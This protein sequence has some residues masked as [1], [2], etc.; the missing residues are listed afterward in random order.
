[1]RALAG[2][3]FTPHCSQRHMTVTDTSPR[4]QPPPLHCH[5]LKKQSL[6][7]AQ[8]LLRA[9]SAQC[10]RG[11]GARGHS[12]SIFWSTSSPFLHSLRG[13]EEEGENPALPR[14]K[15]PTPK[16]LSFCGKKWATVQRNKSKAK[17]SLN[18]AKAALPQARP[19]KG[20]GQEQ[21]RWGGR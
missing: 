14:Q 12:R 11:C 1:M 21:P 10:H 7:P 2:T 15:K 9:V 8:P 6:Q 16:S 19:Y 5:L 20:P 3:P 18:N 13:E 17:V 4:P